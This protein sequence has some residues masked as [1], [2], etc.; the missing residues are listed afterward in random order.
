MPK[1]SAPF[2]RVAKLRANGLLDMYYAPTELAEELGTD[3]WEIYRKFKLGLPFVQDKRGDLWIHGPEVARWIRSY[4][5]RWRATERR[6]LG[7]GEAYCLRCR[8]IVQMLNPVRTR[9]GK[10]TTLAGTCAVCG[11][12]V[13][14]GIKAT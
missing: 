3:R 5:S 4:E 1:P 12:K 13:H 11:G 8:R 14:R 10:F 6:P 7:P 9:Q 2:S